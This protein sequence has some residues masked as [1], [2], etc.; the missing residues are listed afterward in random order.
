MGA[1]GTGMWLADEG[2]GVSDD[3]PPGG[4]TT[5]N[6]EPDGPVVFAYRPDVFDAERFPA[7]CLPTVHVSNASRRPGA[8]A[9]GRWY[10]A[11]R[12]EPEVRVERSTH[13][14]RAAALAAAGDL[15]RAFDAGEVD[16]RGAYQVLDG[17]RAY[18][19]RLDDLT[20]GS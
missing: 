16:Y 14:S 3:A 8:R 12:I 10:A 17:R 19:D 20:G 18:L 7:A 6:E 4:W 2:D 5:W 13:D 1:G 15:A 11:L 9:S